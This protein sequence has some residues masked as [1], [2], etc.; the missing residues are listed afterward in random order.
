MFCGCHLDARSH[1]AGTG[2]AERRL[3]MN[4]KLEISLPTKSGAKAT[5]VQTLRDQRESA[6]FREASGLRRVHRRF[7]SEEVAV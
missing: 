5:A 2:R 4:D 7:S 3:I 6:E 1:A